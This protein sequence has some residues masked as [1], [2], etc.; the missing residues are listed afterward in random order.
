MLFPLLE[1]RR[2]PSQGVGVA[3]CGEGRVP[4]GGMRNKETEKLEVSQWHSGRGLFSQP[5]FKP[6]LRM[7]GLMEIE[8][9]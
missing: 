9:D 8:K 6:L 7:Q 5:Y 1:G 3:S 2:E 4:L